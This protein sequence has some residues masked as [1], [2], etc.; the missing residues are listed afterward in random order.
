MQQIT[1]CYTSLVKHLIG[2]ALF[3][4]LFSITFVKA[5]DLNVD[6]GRQ[7][8][9]G[10]I[11]VN[12]LSIPK[13]NVF[14]YTQPSHNF[15]NHYWLT[16]VVFYFLFSIAGLTSLLV[17]KEILIF[18]SVGFV[19]Y[20]SFKK[21][22]ALAAGL[23]ALFVF[24]FFLVR[25]VIRPELFGYLFFSLLFVLLLTYPRSKK[26]VYLTPLI[27]LLWVNISIT[28]VFGV[29]IIVIFLFKTINYKKLTYSLKQK[30][31]LLLLLSL[32]VLLIN[33]RGIYGVLEPFFILKTP[34]YHL[35]EMK[36]IFAVV[37]DMPHPVYTYIL[38][39]ITLSPI[40]CVYIFYRCKFILGIFL[41]VFLITAALH[42]RNIIFFGLVLIPSCAFMISDLVQKTF[43][44]R[45]NNNLKISVQIFL[46]L[47]LITLSLF[48]INNSFYKT[49]DIKTKFGGGFY[50]DARPATEFMEASKLSNKIF[51]NFNISGYFIYKMFPEYKPFVDNRPEAYSSS[52][53]EDTYLRALENDAHRQKVFEKY[54][55][56]TVFL[57]LDDGD[58]NARALSTVLNKNKEWRLVYLDH[59]IVI[60]SRD[61]R[62]KDLK[63]NP[64]ILEKEIENKT[65]Y[66]EL[67]K[68]GSNLALLGFTKL[69]ENAIQKT[70]KLNPSSCNIKRLYYEYYNNSGQILQGK[71]LRSNN[72]HCFFYL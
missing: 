29:F 15:T 72:W 21:Y 10:G 44:G 45:L 19:L 34:V 30:E 27:M 20:Y 22:G 37:K 54:S 57:Q 51:N 24:P 7:I 62:L 53:F 58:Q 25:N 56:Q 59:S 35:T 28:F 32:G 42:N 4:F 47:T 64:Q 70:E 11:I 14:S 60:F 17:F 65:D 50:E 71:D 26:F 6:L 66:L 2:I 31:V 23:P 67:G 18:L 63:S 52:F 69:A 48:L 13:T 39:L 36:S 40:L 46:S 12:T 55:I 16:E 49:F 9:S 68:L 1:I 61:S 38:W 3:I 33:P 5:N 8:I 41:T 43:K